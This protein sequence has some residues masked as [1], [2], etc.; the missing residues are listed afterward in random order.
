MCMPHKDDHEERNHKGDMNVLP[1]GE[2]F[3]EIWI[4]Q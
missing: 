4:V 3:L 1:V 2:R